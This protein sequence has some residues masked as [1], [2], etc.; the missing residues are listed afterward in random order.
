MN[1]RSQFLS[2][3]TTLTDIL[4]KEDYKQ[5]FLFGSEKQFASR[6]TLLETHGTVEIHD[7]NWYKDNGLLDK[8]YYVFWGFEDKKLYAYAKNELDTLASQSKPFMLGLLT[9]DTHMPNGYVCNL[10]RKDFGTTDKDQMKN[11]IACADRQVGDFVS[12]IQKQDWYE[13]TT[14]V[15]MGDHLFMTGTGTV[16]FDHDWISGDSIQ[17]S[18]RRWLDILINDKPS[19]GSVKSSSFMK[20]RT[21]SSFDMFPTILSSIGCSIQGD[22][23]GFGTN[24]YSDKKTLCERY[25]VDYINSQL[26]EKTKQYIEKY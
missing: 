4:A 14:I 22:R 7:I 2:H 5:L 18:S 20:N 13:N 17:N 8:D 11:V 21:F 26:M 6:S 23:L 19:T 24:L 3:A 1:S 12:W 10:C 16:F 25:D 15:I 9:V